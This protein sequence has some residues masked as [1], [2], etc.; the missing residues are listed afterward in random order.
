V[1]KLQ[2]FFASD[3]EAKY[4]RAFDPLKAFPE[5]A[6]AYHSGE[7][8]SSTL[9]GSGLNHKYQ[10]RLERLPMGK[11]SNLFGLFVRYEEKKL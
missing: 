1:S 6:R 7:S 9:P 5:K 4:A 3:D 2:H 10:T 8:L 11:H